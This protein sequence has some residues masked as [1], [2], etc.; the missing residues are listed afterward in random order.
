VPVPRTKLPLDDQLIDR[1][2]SEAGLFHV[3]DGGSPLP[4]GLTK[5][6]LNALI[7]SVGPGAITLETGCG[8]STVVFAA[9]G[10]DHTVVTPNEGEAERV[11]EFCRT[12][13]VS[14]ERVDFRIGSSDRLLVDWSTPL[15]LLLI[16]GAHRF[17]FPFIDWHYAAS[18][19]KVGGRLF[20]DDVAIPTVHMLYEFLC[21]E[22]EWAL[23]DIPGDKLAVFEKK[24]EPADDLVSD[25]ELQR[26]NQALRYSHVPPSRRWRT[27]R[28][29][30]MIRTR[31]RRLFEQGG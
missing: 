15:D 25:W 13:G 7:Q 27:W 19:L 2:A 14:L 22:D 23:V 8:G 20:V 6:P 4:R 21:S 16:D 18:H 11:R 31:L 29:R 26:Y 17:P 28:D 30:A 5:E 3:G 10:A 12:H 9:A 1:L 24:A